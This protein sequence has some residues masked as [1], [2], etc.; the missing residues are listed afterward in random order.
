MPTGSRR[1]TTPEVEVESGVDVEGSVARIW[2]ETTLTINL[3][4]YE[5]VKISLGC[6]RSVEDDRTIRRRAQRSLMREH[7]DMLSTKA[8]EVRAMWSN[9]E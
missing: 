2:S 3:G 6:S 4:D 8:A 5:S 9:K 7:E 1:R